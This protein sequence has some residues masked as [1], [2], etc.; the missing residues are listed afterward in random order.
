MGGQRAPNSYQFHPRAPSRAV[1]RPWARA[2]G[3]PQAWT[4][5]APRAAT[6]ALRLRP[7]IRP[8]PVLQVCLPQPFEIVCSDGS[9]S[10]Q[11][12]PRDSVRF[13]PAP[14]STAET[15]EYKQIASWTPLSPRDSVYETV[16]TPKDQI[17]S[18]PA[19][20]VQDPVPSV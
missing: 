9:G 4:C 2:K 12:P 8:A 7:P 5:R 19:A 16:L 17:G 11:I 20:G 10:R 15:L 13:A 3:P 18:P 14:R 6:A 1:E